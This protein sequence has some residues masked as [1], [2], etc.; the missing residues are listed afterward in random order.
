MPPRFPITARMLL[1][2]SS[3]ASIRNCPSTKPKYVV[4]QITIVD[5]R[6]IVPALRIK[7]T[8]HAPHNASGHCRPVGIWYA[9][10]SITKG[11]RV[12]GEH[13]RLLQIIPEQMI[14]A[15]P[16]NMPA[17]TGAL[18]PKHRSGD[19]RD[20]GIFA[21]QGI[22]VVVI[23][24]MRRSLSFSMVRDAMIPGTPHPFRSA[25]GQRTFR[26]GQ[27]TEGTVHDDRHTGHVTAALQECQEDKQHKNLR[28]KSQHRADTGHNRQGSG[29]TAS[30]HPMESSRLPTSTGIPGTQI[31]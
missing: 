13:F 4:N 26:K 9:G 31:P 24:V 20:K 21:P 12:S 29:R 7:R 11:S 22:K 23:I 18:L 16:T 1:P 28:H 2:I 8:I 25:S 30:Q 27:F 6:M 15:T 10:S 17:A 14:A 5:R 19:H 3:S